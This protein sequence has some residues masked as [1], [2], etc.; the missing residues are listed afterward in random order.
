MRPKLIARAAVVFTLAFVAFNAAESFAQGEPQR[1][2]P[3][4]VRALAQLP[5]QEPGTVRIVSLD[6]LPPSMR[7]AFSLTAKQSNS[8][9]AKQATSQY[10]VTT[11]SPEDLAFFERVEGTAVRDRK[12]LL[13]SMSGPIAKFEPVGDAAKLAWQGFVREVPASNGKFNRVTQI[14]RASS[15]EMVSLMQWDLAAAGTSVLIVRENLNVAVNGV[16]AT[17]VAV[18][19]ETGRSLWRLAWISGNFQYEISASGYGVSPDS[20]NLI[21][22]LAEAV[23]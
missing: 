8:K 21:L 15:G 3:F 16:P 5:S 6:E 4:D 17:L 2:P 20:A 13:E 1:P 19:D 10:F 12:L 9:F 23:R 14:F 22:R 7:S 18:T 11:G